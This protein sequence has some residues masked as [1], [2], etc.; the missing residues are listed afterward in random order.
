MTVLA[1]FLSHMT[2]YL[3]ES[4]W[5]RIYLEPW[6]RGMQPIV[7]GIA[8]SIT[9]ARKQR[10]KNASTSLLSPSQPMGDVVCIEGRA[11]FLVKYLLKLPHR[12]NQKLHISCLFVTVGAFFQPLGIS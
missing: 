10:K 9:L 4:T 1:T 2:R 5:G 6:F 8:W 11:S 12:Q 3:R 7:A